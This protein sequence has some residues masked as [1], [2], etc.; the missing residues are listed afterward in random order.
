MR[1]S[2]VPSQ[3]TNRIN[4]GRI[5]RFVSAREDVSSN[6]LYF[7]A[8]TGTGFLLDKK[9]VKGMLFSVFT[10]RF[11]ILSLW[12]KAVNYRDAIMSLEEYCVIEEIEEAKT[13][14]WLRLAHLGEK[15]GY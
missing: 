12:R 3:I 11:G 10:Y 1:I 14:H 13:V 4:K 15:K 9:P 5:K 7:N 8:E 2:L 6:V